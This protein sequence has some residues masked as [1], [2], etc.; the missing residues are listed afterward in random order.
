[1]GTKNML[2][3]HQQTF[4]T[5]AKEAAEN[6]KLAESKL[7][8]A[9]ENLNAAENELNAI[10]N[11]MSG[12]RHEFL[13][14][15]KAIVR[16]MYKHPE[17]QEEIDQALAPVLAYKGAMPHWRSAKKEYESKFDSK[18]AALD[19]VN[20]AQHVYNT[21]KSLSNMEKTL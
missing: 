7:H 17:S 2:H 18:L 5:I 10:E 4:A 8:K 6:L 21:I 11:V 3:N 9:E 15:A 14:V 1:M 19:E 13:G 16:M 12:K 20:A